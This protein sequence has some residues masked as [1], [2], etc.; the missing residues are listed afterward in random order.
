MHR[1]ILPILAAL[2]GLAAL[3]LI[4]LAHAAGDPTTDDLFAEA[5]RGIAS[6]DW[7][8]VA[9]AGLSLVV[10]GVRALLA[11]RWPNFDT[12]IGGV[13][14]TAAL[15]GFG[16][17]GHAWLAVGPEKV[18]TATTLIGAVKVWAGA[19]F[20]YVTGKKLLASAAAAKK[21]APVALVLLVALALP[22]C[23]GNGPGP[24]PVIADSVID[25]LGKER[26]K[27]D[28]LLFELSPLVFLSSPDW[29][30]VYQRAKLAGAEVGGCVI[31]ELVQR[32]LS[33]VPGR[34]APRGD[35]SWAA[36]QALEEF[37]AVEAGGATFRTAYGN[38]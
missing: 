19:V 5:Y 38:L 22:A 34:T 31:A 1:F 10:M 13:V 33:P 24:G 32:Y 8:L 18:A 15:A 16:A 26:P 3:G 4:T 9:G 12:D 28:A 6:G 21:T 14:L 7:W 29:A 11:R 20:A 37:R 36:H 27:I 17:L 25:C 2:C 30:A 23:P 35:A